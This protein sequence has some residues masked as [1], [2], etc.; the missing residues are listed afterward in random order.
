MKRHGIVRAVGSMVLDY[1]FPPHCPA[2]RLPTHAE[3]NFCAT[4]FAALQLIAEPMCSCCGIPFVVSIAPGAHCPDCLN[5]PPEFSM[6]RAVMVYDAVSMPLVTSLKFGD[7]WAG[8]DRFS[9]MM[10]AAGAGV[11]AGADMLVPVPL[12]WRRLLRRKFNQSA[13]LAYGISRHSAVP[14]APDILE[15]VLYTK[16]Q[17]RLDR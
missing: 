16:P 11:L 15:R 2:C 8:I 6:A 3:G 1:V 4:C 13:L 5:T 12:H 14:T 17:M 9:R 10:H 7:Q